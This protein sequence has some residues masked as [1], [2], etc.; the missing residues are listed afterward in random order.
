MGNNPVS[1]SG[2]SLWYFLWVLAV[3]LLPRAAVTHKSSEHNE[4]MYFVV[5]RMPDRVTAP[6]GDFLPI[7]LGTTLIGG[8]ELLGAFDS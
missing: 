4:S 3:A 7:V 5:R 2:R 8:R 6:G 1:E